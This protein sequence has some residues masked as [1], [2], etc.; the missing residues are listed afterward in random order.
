MLPARSL[1][2]ST[3]RSQHN[4]RMWCHVVPVSSLGRRGMLAFGEQQW[5]VTHKW[6]IYGIYSV[7][8]TPRWNKTKGQMVDFLPHSQCLGTP[9]WI[10]LR[11][12]ARLFIFQLMWMLLNERSSSGLICCIRCWICFFPLE[13]LRIVWPLRDWP[14]GT[15]GMSSFYEDKLR[16]TVSLETRGQTAQKVKAKL[17]RILRHA[18]SIFW[19]VN[20]TSANSLTY[21]TCWLSTANSKIVALHF[22]RPEL[23][24]C[25]TSTTSDARE[26]GSTFCLACFQC[27][28]LKGVKGKGMEWARGKKR[29][30]KRANIFNSCSASQ[31]CMDPSAEDKSG[32]KEEYPQPGSFITYWCHS[33]LTAC[34]RLCLHGVHKRL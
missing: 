31:R 1:V 29:T 27:H 22:L 14:A 7:S 4:D 11:K 26:S 33:Q 13:V 9:L 3:L 20:G 24:S 21:A 25:K 23:R 16:W 18:E 6:R 5:P 19:L 17:K 12:F 28:E 34:L 30:G 15:S 2:G 10:C 32:Q 8:D